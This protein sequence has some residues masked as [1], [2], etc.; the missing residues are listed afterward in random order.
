MYTD[1][2]IS[3][4]NRKTLS[5]IKTPQNQHRTIVNIANS[6]IM[7][8]FCTIDKNS[9]LQEMTF[10]I[11]S[12]FRSM[13]FPYSHCQDLTYLT[14]GKR[15]HSK[16]SSVQASRC[17]THIHTFFCSW[18]LYFWSL[19]YKLM[20]FR[21]SQIQHATVHKKLAIYLLAGFLWHILPWYQ[22]DV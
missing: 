16:I 7:S 10:Y 4:P 14:N 18:G 19:S 6:N 1:R 5:L 22:N 2:R 21:F 20:A 9:V 17:Q 11:K 12:L 3:F 15:G 13:H 8:V